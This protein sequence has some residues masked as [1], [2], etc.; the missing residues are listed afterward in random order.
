MASRE[1]TGAEGLPP[2][3]PGPCWPPPAETDQDARSPRHRRQLVACAAALLLGVVGVVG[4]LLP[5]LDGQKVGDPDSTAFR[6]GAPMGFF[7][8]AIALVVGIILVSRSWGS[9]ALRVVS[10]LTIVIGGIGWTAEG[11]ALPSQDR[12][13]TTP[14]V[15]HCRL[16]KRCLHRS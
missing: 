9:T 1:H 5:A 3:W 6:I 8:G 4:A 2:P 10:I 16:G 12:C 7:G 13:A 15:D 14:C 11:A